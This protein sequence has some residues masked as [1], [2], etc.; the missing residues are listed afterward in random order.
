[1]ATI[2]Q[3]LEL[4]SRFSS[5]FA[6]A[7]SQSLEYKVRRYGIPFFNRIYDIKIHGK[8]LSEYKRDI[9]L[10]TNMFVASNID[11]IEKKT[12]GLIKIETRDMDNQ[13]SLPRA[14]KLPKEYELF[15]K[16]LSRK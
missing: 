4:Y 8:P 13:L 7:F 5:S 6:P 10:S 14:S 16:A 2:I 3:F 11:L 15:I 1:V 12:F 9:I